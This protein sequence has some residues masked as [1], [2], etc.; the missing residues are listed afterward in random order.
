MEQF[1]YAKKDLE[2]RLNIVLTKGEK[3][4]KCLAYALDRLV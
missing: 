1:Q 4:E 2:K 3:I